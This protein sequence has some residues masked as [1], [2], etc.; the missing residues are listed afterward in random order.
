MEHSRSVS[1][2]IIYF[3]N[4]NIYALRSES[5]RTEFFNDCR[6]IHFLFKIIAIGIYTGF[7][8]V[9]QF[10][11]ICQKFLF[12]DL[13]LFISYGLLDLNNVRKVESFQLHF[14]L[15]EQKIV[16]QR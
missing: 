10:M 15:G 13:L 12:L 1:I 8:A 2:F 3:P 6:H 11:E 14:E 5:F 4:K 9:V 7:S 16:W